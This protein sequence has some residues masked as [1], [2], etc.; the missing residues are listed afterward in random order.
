L[1]PE[2]VPDMNGIYFLAR[3]TILAYSFY[4]IATMALILAGKDSAGESSLLH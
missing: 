1:F 2:G 3:F 4:S